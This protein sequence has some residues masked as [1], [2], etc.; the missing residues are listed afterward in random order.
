M[1]REEAKGGNGQWHALT[2]LPKAFDPGKDIRPGSDHFFCRRH[3][4]HHRH[5]YQGNGNDNDTC[6]PDHL[7]I[8]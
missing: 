5:N 7:S 2:R 4:H 8:C 1:L 3:H 6:Q